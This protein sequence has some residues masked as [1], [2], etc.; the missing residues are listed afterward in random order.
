LK[1]IKN[2]SKFLE[3][4]INTNPG[5][6]KK[7]T[8]HIIEIVDYLP[9]VTISNGYFLKKNPTKIKIFISNISKVEKLD[10]LESFHQGWKLYLQKKPNRS[11]CKDGKYFDQVKMTEC[12]HTYSFFEGEEFSYLWEKPIFDNT[13]KKA[14]EYT[15]SWEI[16]AD[17]IKKN[18]SKEY[19]KENPDGSID[20]EF[21]LYFKPQSYFYLGL[22]ISGVTLLG[23]VGYLIYDWRKRKSPIT[24]NF[25]A[26]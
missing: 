2:D 6:T 3:E 4:I 11:W 5:K 19:Y 8:D 25:H 12:E 9:R 16:D 13:H 10:F 26:Y 24:H 1:N 17:Y 23:C 7:I 18:F 21:I 15:N 20:V 22:G 14:Y